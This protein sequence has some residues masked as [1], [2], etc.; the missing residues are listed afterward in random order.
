MEGLAA[1]LFWGFVFW[2]CWKWFLGKFVGRFKATKAA[3]A[4]I[5]ARQI[6]D[7]YYYEMAAKEVQQNQI[8]PGLWAKAWSDVGGDETKAKAL[9]LK[10]R[11]ATMKDEAAK[12]I[13]E[14]MNDS[15]VVG[16]ATS[17]VIVQCPRCNQKIR[18]S[19]GGSGTIVCSNCGGS[20]K[21]ET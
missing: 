15:A 16:D 3:K 12:F 14:G 18:V 9:Y 8:R 6:S 21:I 11:V 1:L 10:L 13:F 19:A 2:V 17:K 7:E 5:K 4:Q 20:F